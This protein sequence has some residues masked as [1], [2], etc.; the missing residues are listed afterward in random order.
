MGSRLMAHLL[1]RVE[2]VVLARKNTLEVMTLIKVELLL[3]LSGRERSLHLLSP[4]G[5]RVEA[6]VSN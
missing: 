4:T 2:I 3:A 6:N 5:R 1:M